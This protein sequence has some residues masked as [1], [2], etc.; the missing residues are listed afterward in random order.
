MKQPKK[1]IVFTGGHHNSAL[2]VA[3]ALRDDGYRVSW[4]GHKYSMWGDKN[5]SA[6]YREVTAAGIPFY[7]LKAGKF[8]RTY[9][10]LKLVRIPRGF[11]EAFRYLRAVR[12][13]IIVSFGGY[14]A[15]P[16]VIVGWLMGIP[17]VT[18][19]QTAASGLSNQLIGRFVKEIFL[20]FDSSR[21]YFPPAKKVKVIGL[22]LGG[23][24][25]QRLANGNRRKQNGV[26][27]VFITGGKQGSHVI[28]KL[29]AA[30]VGDLVKKYRVVHQTGSSTLYDD[31]TMAKAEKEKLGRKARSRYVIVDYLRE[32]ANSEMLLGADLVVGRAGAHAVYYLG[33]L[34]RPALLIPIPWVVN[35]EQQKNAEI[36]KGNGSAEVLSEK[37]LTPIVLLN[38]IQLM[39]ENLE[40]Y[41]KNAAVHRNDF[42]T[43]A[44]EKMVVEIKRMVQ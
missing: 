1:K 16:V 39:M 8:Y 7:E 29:V 17:S 33:V 13:D 24:I 19:E 40:I 10:P 25:L 15:V 38:K 4:F 18:H 44:K 28:N 30:M 22:P 3:A 37:G 36:L 31:F 12:P 6:E 41:E 11:V 42:P 5:P 43:D 14:L 20:T 35:N 21:A 9:H 27:T 26:R 2:V 23:D 34:A 32:E